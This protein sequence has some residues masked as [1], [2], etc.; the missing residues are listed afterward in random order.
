MRICVLVDN[1]SIPGGPEGEHGLSLYLESG[2]SK[3]LFDTG[4]GDRFVR[5]AEIMSIDLSD[6]RAAVISHGHYDHGGGVGCF[7]D[8]NKNAPVYIHSKAFEPHLSC[9]Q[10]GRFADIGIDPGLKDNERIVLTRGRT[11]IYEGIVIFDEV[12]GAYPV[13]RGNDN[14]FT[15]SEGN[16]RPDSFEHEQNLI[17]EENGKYVLITG[18]AHRGVANIMTG[19]EN[20]LG[21]FPDVVIGGFHLGIRPGNAED[22]SDVCQ[23]SEV[24]LKSEAEFYTCHC[25]EDSAYDVMRSAMGDRIHKLKTGE[26]L[27]L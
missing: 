4:Q 14:L 20:I 22:M 18:C 10:D 8:A 1:N 27:E 16:I 24:L 9:R 13:P 17:A 26:I 2:S 15:G 12:G 21:R 5:N 23:V 25:T 19:A 3:I 11:E 6:V 7:L